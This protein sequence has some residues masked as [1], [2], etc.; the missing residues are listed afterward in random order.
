[1]QGAFYGVAVSDAMLRGA[2]A[3]VFAAAAATLPAA[4]AGSTAQNRTGNLVRL[5]DK[6]TLPSGAFGEGG[7]FHFHVFAQAARLEDAG[8]AADAVPRAVFFSVPDLQPDA[9]PVWVG[10]AAA[11]V[12]ALFP[13]EVRRG[14]AALHHIPPALYAGGH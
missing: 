12:P 8:N 3:P 14:E 2:S 7:A 10:A 4:V 6:S 9:A 1:M 13:G 5:P 11:L